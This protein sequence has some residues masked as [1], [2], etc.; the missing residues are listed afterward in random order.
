ML[1]CLDI[2]NSHI[3]GGVFNNDTIQLTF[4]YSTQKPT[5]SD[6]YG[7]FLRSVLIENGIDPKTI[8]H[9]TIASV[10]PHLDYTIHAACKKYFKITPTLVK[11]GIKTGIQL[12]INTPQELGADRI[13]T[14]VGAIEQFPNANL[15]VV[16]LGT[17][18]T[19]CAI[20]KDKS[21]LGG[22][23]MPGMHTSM[24]ALQ[25]V[26]ARLPFVEII[27]PTHTLG[28]TT[29]TNIQAGLYYSQL[30][31]IKEMLSHL[32][33]EA[34]AN[35]PFTTIA[36]GGFASLFEEEKVFDVIIPNLVLHGLNVIHKK[37]IAN[38]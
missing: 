25:Q 5:T 9:I 7:L 33:H 36:T 23:I 13:A 28:K 37:N 29:D 34:F 38:A 6:E 11:P 17:A 4:R 31:G 21:Y 3:F 12:A 22:A 2:G 19:L 8:E 20:T 16:D 1:L 35:N 10:V 27:T 14:A 24:K 30:G 26:A 32:R 18:T 15:V